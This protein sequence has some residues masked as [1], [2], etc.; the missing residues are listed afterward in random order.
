MT[1]P[2]FSRADKFRNCW[3]LSCDRQR[4]ASKA[5]AAIQQSV[6]ASLSL[7]CRAIPVDLRR[8]RGFSRQAGTSQVFGTLSVVG[9]Y[10]LSVV[11]R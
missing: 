5:R 2:F 10:L 9:L 6:V 7:V 11:R 1:F 3:F 8:G 4:P